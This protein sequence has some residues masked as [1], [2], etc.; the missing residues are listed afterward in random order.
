VLAGDV[1]E[2][3]VGEL[4][5]AVRVE[6]HVVR[7]HVPVRHSLALRVRESGEHRAR[8]SERIAP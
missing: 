8:D 7:L 6:Q 2:A 3:E 1:G 4:R 5:R